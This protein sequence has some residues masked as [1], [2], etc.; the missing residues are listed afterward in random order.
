MSSLTKISAIEGTGIQVPGHDIDTD[1]II[2]ARFLKETS[3]EK[4]GEYLFY[5]QRFDT[6]GSQKEHPL[7]TDAGRNAS[8]LIS[9]RNF[10]CGSS[11]E[12]APQ[13]IKRFGIQAVIAESFAEIFAGNCKAIG[14]PVI[15]VTEEAILKLTTQL[16]RNPQTHIVIDLETKHIRFYEESLIIHIPD[17][18][19]NAFLNGTWDILSVLKANTEAI[20]TTYEKLPYCQFKR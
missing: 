10:G 11:R 7:N 3:F 4:M 13:A 20:Q 1:Q 19:R 8:I 18:H 17:A 5:D 9:G 15:Q 16:D 2:P 6:N 14:V 12:H